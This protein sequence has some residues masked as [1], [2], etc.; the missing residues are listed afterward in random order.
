MKTIL[1]IGTENHRIILSTNDKNVV[2]KIIEFRTL[3]PQRIVETLCGSPLYISLD[4]MQSWKSDT[5]ARSHE[6]C[7]FED[8]WDNETSSSPQKFPKTKDFNK[9]SSK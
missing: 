7:R 9:I 2:L 3:K 6:G 4:I 1:Y 8:D 5:R